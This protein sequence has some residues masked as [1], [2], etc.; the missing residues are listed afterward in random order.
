MTGRRYVDDVC[1][2]GQHADDIPAYGR[3]ADDVRMTSGRRM[4]SATRNLQRI[5]TLVSSAR[6][7][8][9]VRTRLQFPDY[10]KL[11]SRGQLC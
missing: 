3:R 7:P 1:M 11:N 10:F 5:L 8:P 4:S 6:R 9:V 2:C